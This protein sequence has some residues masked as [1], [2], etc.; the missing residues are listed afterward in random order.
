MT[1]LSM[2]SMY[3]ATLP[4]PEA[5]GSWAVNSSPRKGVK[6]INKPNTFQME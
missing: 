1:I 5:I 4:N 2:I 6:P 3:G